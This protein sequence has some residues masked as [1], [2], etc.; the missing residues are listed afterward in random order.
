MLTGIGSAFLCDASKK[1]L[2]VC[3]LVLVCVHNNLHH[4]VRV[5][6]ARSI[7][8]APFWIGFILQRLCEEDEATGRKRLHLIFSLP[9]R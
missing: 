4:F 1:S 2:G 7:V 9:F 3:G 6:V 5:S 8:L